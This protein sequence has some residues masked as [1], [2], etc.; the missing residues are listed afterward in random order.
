MR[1][2]WNHASTL[3]AFSMIELMVVLAIMALLATITLTS[4]D[5]LRR[6]LVSLELGRLYHALNYTRQLALTTNQPQTLQF[7]VAHQGYSYGANT[8]TLNS[9]TKFGTRPQSYGPPAD[10]K[11]LIVHPITF[12]HGRVTAEPTGVLSPGALYL[13]DAGASVT[14]ALT[15]PISQATLLR[16]YHL[17]GHKWERL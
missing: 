15:V 16:Q 13:T 12:A 8:T 2:S 5:F 14:Y 10:P 9:A 17:V 4:F 3:P 6:S 7:D 1:Y 11:T